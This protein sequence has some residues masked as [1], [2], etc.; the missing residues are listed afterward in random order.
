MPDNF[1]QRVVEARPQYEDMPLDKLLHEID[2][3]DTQVSKVFDEAGEGIDLNK[4]TSLE[5]NTTEKAHEFSALHARQT[6]SKQVYAEKREVEAARQRVAAF[7]A[8]GP[9]TQEEVSK[10]RQSRV[11]R[12]FTDILGTHDHFGDNGFDMRRMATGQRYDYPEATVHDFLN[13]MTTGS[14]A[15]DDGWP[16]FSP[17]SGRPIEL[18]VER[19]LGVLDFLPSLTIEYE[20]HIF[21]RETSRVQRGAQR[22]AEDG[23]YGEAALDSEEVTVTPQEIGAFI[24][25][26]GK[27]LDDVAA[28]NQY[29]NSRLSYFVRRQLEDDILTSSS[30][31]VGFENTTGLAGTVTQGSDA[32]T[33]EN[34]NIP[35][36]LK[37]MERV[38]SVGEVVPD[39]II[40]RP[41]NWYSA[42]NETGDSG[43]WA[44]GQPSQSIPFRFYGLPVI[45]S[46]GL[47][48]NNAIV[49]AFRPNCA[50]VNRAGVS[51]QMTDSHASNF[52]R[53]RYAFRA[54]VRATLAVYQPKA[55]VKLVDL[56]TAIN[57]GTSS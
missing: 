3:L 38:R 34:G 21:M 10:W 18:V 49:G 46:T 27:Q 29:V 51:V 5:G 39:G 33:K 57:P 22:V 4:V 14:G 16:P 55:F 1:E 42:I 35:A 28:V 25:V 36:L 50:L 12:G 31:I 20:N 24:E 15:T 45:Q 48:A 6:A 13:V 23:V 44:F 47:T 53:R 9:I 56:A 26:S 32:T 54:W 11:P 52:T 30:N 43:A 7:D 19:E 41:D 2:A 40:I 17:R 37:A 8:N